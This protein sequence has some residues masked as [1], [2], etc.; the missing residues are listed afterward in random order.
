MSVRRT[1]CSCVMGDNRRQ[2]GTA[3]TA[4]LVSW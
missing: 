1:P 2:V 4:G 3:P